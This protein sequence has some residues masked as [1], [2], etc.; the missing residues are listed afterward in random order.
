MENSCATYSSLSTA[1]LEFLAA[2]DTG[3]LGLFIRAVLAELLQ[4]Q[5]AA[6]TV[7]EVPNGRQLDRTHSSNTSYRYL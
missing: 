1:E 3:R 4:P 6:T 7:Y 5:L 2:S